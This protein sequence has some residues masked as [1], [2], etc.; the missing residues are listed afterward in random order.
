MTQKSPDAADSERTSF[1]VRRVVLRC[2]LPAVMVA[3]FVLLID[4]WTKSLAL[5][6][7]AELEPYPVIPGILNFTLL[8]N[9]GAAWSL[10]ANAT[11]VVTLVQVLISLIAVWFLIAKVRSTGWAIALGLLLGGACGNL[12]DR[13]LRPPGFGRG[14]VVDFLQLPHWPVFNVADMS[15]VF[16]AISIVVFSLIGIGPSNPHRHSPSP[17]AEESPHD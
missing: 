15:V 1:G 12:Y 17:Q 14:H 5:T 8:F 13:L 11:P 16:A 2:I 3:V 7:L 6:H 4:Q 9:S 10:G